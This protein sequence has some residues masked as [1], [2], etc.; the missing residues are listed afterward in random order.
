[1]LKENGLF[2]ASQK[3]NVRRLMETAP[4]YFDLSNFP[5]GEARRALER[6]AVGGKQSDANSPPPSSPPP[7]STKPSQ[8]KM[9]FVSRPKG[10]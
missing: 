1:M 6:L 4:H 10:N 3:P 8:P 9:N 5:K 2:P 7:S